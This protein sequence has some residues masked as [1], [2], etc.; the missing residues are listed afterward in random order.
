MI[1]IRTEQPDD[2]TAIADVNRKAFGQE[3]E[4]RIVDAL[5]QHG[6]VD[7]SLVA[8]WDGAVVGHIMFSPAT[9]GPVVG[10][11]LA[12]MA[13]LPAFQRR[14][15][16]SLLVEQGLERLRTRGCPFVV[17]IGH[18]AFYP[19]FGFRPA[20]ECG[21]TCEWDVPAEAFM[22]IVLNSAV[23]SRLQGGVVFRPEFSDA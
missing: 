12:P 2:I 6:A 11:A 1:D 23:T 19:R 16:G 18:P 9:V 14:G 17:V 15:I 10:A 7:L 8:L 21:L 22:V 20:A 3:H 13:V 5:R 4:S